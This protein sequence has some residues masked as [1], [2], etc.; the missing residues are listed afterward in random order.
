[1]EKFSQAG[2]HTGRRR[3]RK[4]RAGES[5]EVSVPR[6]TG[7]RPKQVLVFRY[8]KIGDL[9]LSSPIFKAIKDHSPETKVILVA[10]P[11][12]AD[13]L[14][15]LEQIDRIMVYDRGWSLRRKLGFFRSLRA[16]GPSAAFVL[17]PKN[18]AYLMAWYSGAAERGGLVPS[19]RRAA[20]LL[21]RL[22]LTAEEPID[23]GNPQHH[24]AHIL[25]LAA[26][27][28]YESPTPPMLQ[29]PA[30]PAAAARIA[31]VLTR[32][33][34]PQPRILMHLGQWNRCGLAPEAV[35]T[36]CRDVA[37]RFPDAGMILTA[38]EADAPFLARFRPLFDR[39]ISTAPGAAAGE[40]FPHTLLFTNLSF[41][42]WAAAVG[43]A[44]VVLAPDTSAV[45]LASARGVP[46]AVVFAADRRERF[47]REFG[48]W[49]VP[50]RAL[51][52][53]PL[54]ELVPQVLDAI[55]ALLAERA[56]HTPPV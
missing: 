33:P 25:K 36:L 46:V 45:H 30:D 49:Q 12:N 7:P 8:D 29:L 55:G 18:S 9:L 2:Y 24:T 34:L 52:G 32:H 22:F 23:R 21:A 16:L 20:R 42:E 6:V 13:V 37:K 26:R 47:G 53:G 4:H 1:M 19:Y 28:G 38:S 54:A 14:A 44:D 17:S 41:G 56:G 50:F 5:V 39:T 31:E 3:R 27:L 10:S 15:G 43:S 11:Y 51:A 48:P 40:S 35:L